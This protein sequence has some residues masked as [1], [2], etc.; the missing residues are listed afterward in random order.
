MRVRQGPDRGDEPQG[1][2]EFLWLSPGLQLGELEVP[3]V[4]PRV[5]EKGVDYGVSTE[6]LLSS[7]PQHVRHAVVQRLGVANYFR[8]DVADPG[9][10][11]VGEPQ[12]RD[13]HLR[14]SPGNLGIPANGGTR[15][16]RGPSRSS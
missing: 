12:D 10:R 16:G 15:P 11:F 6:R 8:I 2:G 13:R 14:P 4:S 9:R 5:Q 7:D 1:F 3:H